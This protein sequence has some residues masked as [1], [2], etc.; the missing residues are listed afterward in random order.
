MRRGLDLEVFETGFETY[1]QEIL[2]PGSDLYD[3]APARGRG[4]CG[5]LGRFRAA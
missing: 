5:A 2:D 1:R 3:F 4:G